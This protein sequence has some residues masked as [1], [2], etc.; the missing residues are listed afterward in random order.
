[1]C[2]NC[3]QVRGVIDPFNNATVTLT[4]SLWYDISCMV[5]LLV[6]YSHIRHLV[7]YQS[8]LSMGHHKRVS[9]NGPSHSEG[10]FSVELG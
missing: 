4:H 7:F 10:C 2:C 1:M 3:S 9:I 5:S 8:R 6:Y